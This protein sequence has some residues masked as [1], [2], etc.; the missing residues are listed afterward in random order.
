ME[1]SL[2]PKPL[3]IKHTLS[4]HKPYE[5]LFDVSRETEIDHISLS[6]WADLIIVLP[7][8]ANFMSRLCQGKADDLSTAVILASNKDIMLVPA[9]N[10]RMWI[11]PA[12]QENY[13]TLLATDTNLL[14]Q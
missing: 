4:G 8:T 11:N 5:N 2:L 13:K 10:V 6:R 1:K 14:V 7:T 3:S 12:T 9:M